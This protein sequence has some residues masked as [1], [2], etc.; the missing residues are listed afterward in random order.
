MRL[1]LNHARME[2]PRI[3]GSSRKRRAGA[4]LAVAAALHMRMHGVQGGLRHTRNCSWVQRFMHVR[5]TVTQP[6]HT[7]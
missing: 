3:G 5:G 7:R 2:A 6:C 1:Q 4:R